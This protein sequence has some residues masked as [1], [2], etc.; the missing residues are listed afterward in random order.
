M[1]I[2]FQNSSFLYDLFFSLAH[3]LS[4]IILF[5]YG[6]KHKYPKFQW[7]LIIVTGFT[8]FTIGSHVL[9][10]NAE[11]L[12]MLLNGGVWPIS[13]GKS[14]ISG[15][16]M[17]IPAM[18]LLK[19]L[20]KFKY[21]IFEPYALILPISI[22]I[23]RFGCLAAGCC[24]GKPTDLPWGITYNYSNPAHYSQW[25]QGLIS[26]YDLQSLAIH[27][28]QIYEGILCLLIAGV[29]IY[30]YKRKRFVNQLF[31]VSILLYLV[32][33]FNIEFFRA[34]AAH[35]IGI[36]S[37]YG[38]NTVQ[39]IM[40]ILGLIYFFSLIKGR[41]NHIV[42]QSISKVNNSKPVKEYAWFILLFGIILSTPK[43]YSSLELLLLGLL[44]IPL[45][46]IVFWQFFKPIKN[47]KLRFA[48][49]SVLVLGFFSMSQNSLVDQGEDEKSKYNILSFGSNIGSNNMGNSYSYSSG[50]SSGG[51]GTPYTYNGP[52]TI[53][54]VESNFKNNYFVLG[55]GFQHVSERNA[56][57][58]F[59]FEI[60]A[61]YSRMNEFI[62]SSINQTINYSYDSIV[63]REYNENTRN[64]INNFAISPFLKFDYKFIGFGFGLTAGEFSLYNNP[65]EH[66]SNV[67]QF[68]STLKEVQFLPQFHFRLGHLGTVWGEFNYAHRF[69]GI[70]PASELE[71]L[72]GVNIKNG[73]LLRIGASSYHYLVI[74]P[75]FSLNNSIAIEPYIGL[76]GSLFKSVYSNQS[77]F[78]AG[79][80][81][82]Y[83]LKPKSK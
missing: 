10:I 44:F 31:Y 4:W 34:D 5:W 47:Y 14:L 62:N 82:H 80:N 25:E 19:Y 49:A 42:N 12:K 45:S 17:A 6:H 28:V 53:T 52:L 46:A 32:V 20:L 65:E 63:N 81:F 72:L 37:Y 54:N 22:A 1:N 43:F 30:L 73:N 3:I 75:Q 71:F 78:E 23:Q 55:A 56:N 9:A 18:L 58:K 68:S 38:L 51:C 57:R 74:R 69:P 39:W 16:L 59:T 48:T 61:S 27:P 21:K 11:S 67:E 83:K 33:R 64:I 2:D 8:F 13:K 35:T 24:Y 70:S 76:G 36:N 77:G 40:M 15:L 60:N 26:K 41:R 50:G 66:Y 7:L 29:I 79:L